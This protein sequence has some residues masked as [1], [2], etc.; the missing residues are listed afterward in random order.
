MWTY[1]KNHRDRDACIKQFLL[2]QVY[3]EVPIMLIRG[4]HSQESPLVIY[5]YQRSFSAIRTK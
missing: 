1:D 3:F 2:L 5:K 4:I